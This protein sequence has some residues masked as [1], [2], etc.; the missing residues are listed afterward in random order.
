VTRVHPARRLQ[1]GFGIPIAMLIALSAV[2]YRSVVA[3]TAGAAWLRHTHQV[4]EQLAGLLSAT[5]DIEAG[6]RGF[7]LVGDETFLAPYE[8]GR[9]KVSTDLAAI[10][11]QTADNPGQQQRIARLTALIDQMTEFGNE[12]VRLRRSAGAQA[13]SERVASDDGVRLT[14]DI[15]N[16]IHD[17]GDDE[18]RLLV[19]RQ[20]TADRDST[21]ITLVLELGIFGSILVLGLAGWMVSRDAMARWE[22][23]QALRRSEDRL[24][25]ERDRAQRYLNTP[26]VVL[27][28][29]DLDGRITLANRYACALLGWPADELLGR[30]FTSLLPARLQDEQRKRFDD[31]VAGDLPINESRVVTRSGEERLIEWRNTL[32]HDDAGGVVG[33][34]SSGTDITER[35]RAEDEIREGAQRSARAER[36]FRTLFAANPLPMWIYDLATL[37]F[38]EV[39]EAA[40]QRY[41]YTRDEFLAMT[42]A[43]IRPTEDVERLLAQ[44]GQPQEPWEDAGNWRHCV[45]SGEIIDVDITSHTIAFAG[46]SAALIV[47]QDI[48]ARTRA[49]EAIRHHAQL[50]E[51]HVARV[52]DAERRTNL[53]LEAGQMGIWDLDLA[54]D[55]SV[56]SLRHDQIFGYTTLRHSWGGKDLAAAV[57]PEDRPAARRAFK[58]AASTGIFTLECR[59]RWPDASLHWIHGQGHGERDAPGHVARIVGIVTD[60]TERKRAEEELRHHAQLSALSAAVG[61]ALTDT[62]SLAGDLQQC[63]EALVT[64]LDAAFARIWILNEREGIL[65]LQASAGLY[66]H[67][68]GPHGRIPL[69]QFTIG[70]IARDRKPHLTNA[71]IGDP[72][73]ADQEWARRE[74]MVAFAGHPLIVEDRVVGVM[75][76]FARHTLSD[77]VISALASV[78]DHIAL[79]IERHRSAN[80]LRTAEERVR[81][82]LEA[83]GVG[84][85]DRDYTTG[86]V[87][88]SE[89][90]EAQY[91]LQPGTFRG[92][93]EAAVERIHPDDRDSV[94]ETVGSAMRSGADFSIQNRAIWPDGTVRWLSGR[95]RVHL[96]AHGEPL[97]GV[98]ISMDVTERHTLEAQYQQA[99]KMEAIGQLAGGVAHDFN[100]LLTVILGYCELLL[101]DRNPDDPRQAD[102]AEIQ[103]AGTSAAGLTRQLL[104]F[105]RKEIIEPKVLDVNVVVAAMET[106]LGRLIREDVKIVLALRPEVA[107]IKADRGQ[108]EQIVVNLAVNARD[109]MPK[110]G[111][112]TIQ[113]ANV[114]LD[115]HY[116]KTHLA[117]KPGPYVMLT[118]S[119][120]G[121]GMTPQVQER[122]F[123]PFFTTKEVGK[124]TGL[125][126]ATV[127]GIVMRNGGT[128]NVYS[129]VGKGTSFKVYFPTADASEIAVEAPPPVSRL[130]AGT[131]TVLIVEDVPGLRELAK[132]LL[133]RQGYTVLVAADA[134]EALHLFERHASIDV[135]LT[136][137]VMPG[138][139]GPELTRQ[140]IERRPHLKV[141]YMSGYT[142][143]TIAHHGVLDPGVAFV[144]KPFTAE[145]LGRKIR[146]VLDHA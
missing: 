142:E 100:N 3:S 21:R 23:E 36:E 134:E 88:W 86:V 146:E 1:F 37:R 123:E 91:G 6:Y 48:T 39:N 72:Q 16:L 32:L 87:R 129:E 109:A 103:R 73:V 22:T 99:Q 25:H 18:E 97:R 17:I 43:D 44:P 119:D 83:A 41:G 89:I 69:G 101:A 85:W 54:T 111:T 143:E 26:E 58:D 79:G 75:A 12:I 98:G 46:Q 27:L 106:M 19:A 141:I 118:V 10:A 110:G 112:L 140:L 128:I 31:V 64:H 66:T 55:T 13:A 4:I 138:A 139:S 35:T 104:A 95:G 14:Q 82:A 49:E 63:V 96:G 45:K 52:D 131:H 47:A 30:A 105:S 94:R 51:N 102:I 62:D 7:A 20:A 28:A 137:I 77:A 5:Q 80:A 144:H 113:T 59:I 8:E 2:S 107:C 132:R 125:G 70:R 124:G 15:R 34:F 78:A 116:P 38:L 60:I 122:L 29:L 90:L 33:T 76:L 130:R 81:F 84:I 57:V 65:E 117:V 115:E 9:A 53:A 108:V 92:T 42:I 68:N 11:T 40:V 61:L 93:A 145:A 24:R 50:L 133:E 126:L 67:L 135:L 120:T 127:H 74:G 121:S 136:D 114:A 56:R 71:V